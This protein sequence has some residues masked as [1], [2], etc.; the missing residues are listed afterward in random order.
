MLLALKA[1]NLRLK[2][3]QLDVK[4]A[5]LISKLHEEVYVRQP[6]E[7]GQPDVIWRLLKALDGLKQAARA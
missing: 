7:A 4:T 5:F 2:M 1:A 6:P 3:R